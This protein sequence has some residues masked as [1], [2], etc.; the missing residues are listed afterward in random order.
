MKRLMF[1]IAS[2]L[3]IGSTI[4]YAAPKKLTS[5]EQFKVYGGSVTLRSGTNAA[6]H[7]NGMIKS[8]YLAQV[9]PYKIGSTGTVVFSIEKPLYFTLTGKVQGGY[10]D[11]PAVLKNIYGEFKMAKGA[12]ISFHETGAIQRIDLDGINI[13]RGLPGNKSIM[14]KSHIIFSD[15]GRPQTVVLASEQ[16]IKGYTFK[17]GSYIEFHEQYGQVKRGVL[18]K[19]YEKKTGKLKLKKKKYAAGKTYDFNTHGDIK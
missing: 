16:K 3:F 7:P 10:L 17:E 9:M 5:D 11:Q 1:I 15:R 4:V 18:A 6:F 8:G 2:L 19:G 12:W 13:L 14:I